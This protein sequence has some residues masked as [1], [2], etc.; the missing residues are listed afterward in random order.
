MG[1]SS[2]LAQQHALCHWHK[3]LMLCGSL[4]FTS[5]TVLLRR[6]ARPRLRRVWPAIAGHRSASLGHYNLHGIY[7]F[8]LYFEFYDD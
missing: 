4:S 3:Q 7:T 5:F 8:M 2:L 6:F 1:L